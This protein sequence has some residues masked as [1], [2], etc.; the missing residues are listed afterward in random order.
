MDAALAA[1]CI[2]RPG[3]S[4]EAIEQLQVAVNLT[5]DWKSRPVSLP[6]IFE[7]ELLETFVA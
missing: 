6:E 1:Y 2:A 5:E 4:M 7:E 3:L